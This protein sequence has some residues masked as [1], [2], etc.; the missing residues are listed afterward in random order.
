MEEFLDPPKQLPANAQ[1][2][3]PSLHLRDRSQITAQHRSAFCSY[4]RSPPG[5]GGSNGR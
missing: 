5:V 1:I 3:R 4:R 2:N